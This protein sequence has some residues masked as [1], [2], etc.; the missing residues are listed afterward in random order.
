M[1][2]S[3]ILLITLARIAIYYVRSKCNTTKSAPMINTEKGNN[4]RRTPNLSQL[5]GGYHSS[6]SDHHERQSKYHSKTTKYPM[7][8]GYFEQTN[9][10]IFTDFTPKTGN[11]TPYSNFTH[12]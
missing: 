1:D 4:V 6:E 11:F 7:K 10:S 2:N 12:T 5:L 8:R 9:L 3:S